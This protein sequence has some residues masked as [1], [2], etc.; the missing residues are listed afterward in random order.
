MGLIHIFVELFI[1]NSKIILYYF[2]EY[3]MV[4]QNLRVWIIWIALSTH[5]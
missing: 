2:N 4:F 5:S 1:C 3:I